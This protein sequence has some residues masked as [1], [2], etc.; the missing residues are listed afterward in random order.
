MVILHTFV[1]EATIPTGWTLEAE[2]P[3]RVRPLAGNPDYLAQL[4]GGTLTIRDAGMAPPPT[5]SYQRTVPPK[6][7]RAELHLQRSDGSHVETVYVNQ[8]MALAFRP[9][10]VLAM[11]R[12]SCAG[13][14][15]SVLRDD[16][17]MIA[18]AAVISVPLGKDVGPE[19]LGS[20]CNAPRPYSSKSTRHSPLPR[21]QSRFRRVGRPG[22]FTKAGQRSGATASGPTMAS[23]AGCRAERMRRDLA[24]GFV[25]DPV[26]TSSAMLAEETHQVGIEWHPARTHVPIGP[27]LIYPDHLTE[28]QNMLDRNA[29][30]R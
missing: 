17:L 12:N 15:V 30:D 3:F 23:S 9:G 22:S 16:E 2:T 11:A 24:L 21:S 13:N 20:R 10:D 5:R 25:P 4:A 14:G 1:V 26:S 19:W 27:I 6:V 7:L 28:R 29:S 18:C 8:S